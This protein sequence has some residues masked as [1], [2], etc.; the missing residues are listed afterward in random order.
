[1]CG[2]QFWLKTELDLHKNVV[3][4]VKCSFCD[5]TFGNVLELN[6]HIEEKHEVPRDEE[7]SELLL[8]G[9]DEI[10]DSTDPLVLEELVRPALEFFLDNSEC[11]NCGV[12]GKEEN[13]NKTKSI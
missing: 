13:C 11:E 1:M 4:L 9:L 2:N 10:S 8:V 7:M 3:H 12:C 6:V 5:D